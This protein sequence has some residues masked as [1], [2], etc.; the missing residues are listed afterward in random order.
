MSKTIPKKPELIYNSI[1][2]QLKTAA[3]SLT[4]A[5][6]N[7][8]VNILKKQSNLNTKYIENLHRI[9]FYDYN[10]NTTGEIGEILNFED[11]FVTDV[12][13]A[14]NSVKLRI[15]DLEKFKV[16]EAEPTVEEDV[17]LWIHVQGE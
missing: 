4:I 7:S 8:V 2:D 3:N 9:L 15:D 6:W 17:S 13:S 11:G 5:E 16:S 1:S 14:I 12:M 10:T